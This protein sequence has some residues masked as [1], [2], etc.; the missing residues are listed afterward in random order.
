MHDRS[1]HL[2]WALGLS[3]LGALSIVP[4]RSGAVAGAA[5]RPGWA[6]AV[7]EM[8]KLGPGARP[9]KSA[10]IEL[11][12]ARGECVGAQVV[13]DAPVRSASMQA[14]ALRRP[15]APPIG[16]RLYREAFLEVVHPSNSEGRE[17]RWP[18]ALIPER[19]A[20]FDEARRAFPVSSTREPVVAYVEICA[21]AAIPGRYEGDVVVRA[22]GRRPVVIPVRLTVRHFALPATSSLPNSFGFSG[23][24]AAAGHGLPADSTNVL[25]LTRLYATA[26]LRHRVSLHGMSMEAPRIVSTDPPK[27]DFSAWDAEVGPF[28]DGTA[29]PNGARFT[30]I[31]VRVPHKVVSDP[32]G[33]EYLRLYAEHLREKG[34]LDRAFVYLKDEPREKDLPEVRRF[35]DLVHRAS[36]QLRALV[37]TSMAPVLDQSIDLWT[38]NLNC[39]FARKGSD[40]CKVVRPLGD[41]AQARARGSRLW[42]Y[43][44][45]GSHGCGE[46]PALDFAHR[47]YFAGW[48]SYMVD[49]DAAL[50][51]AM[52]VLAYRHGID[53]ELY[54]NT[55]EAY[56]PDGAAKKKPD[57]WRDLWRFHGNGDGTLFYPGTPQAIGGTHHVPVESLRLKLIRAGLQDYEVLALARSMGLQAAAEEAAATL[58]PQ[59]YEILRDPEAWQQARDRLADRIEAVQAKRASEYRPEGVVQGKGRP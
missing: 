1:S 58:A 36:P 29:L 26:A 27:I 12:A 52:G 40:Y 51:R 34:W 17:G 37:T 35:A 18:D 30:S 14:S 28:L 49:H 50:N 56:L 16:V 48:P 39:L 25:E 23:I 24:A 6:Y 42:W 13:V 8:V 31:D 21:G 43:Q 15:G 54:F 22:E 9:K 19:D 57:P 47:R 32:R 44:S 55:V 2:R 4:V 3:L 59:P 11:R 46:L 10:S 38:P 5:A 53:G 7:S 33:I 41:Y 45:C 20:Y